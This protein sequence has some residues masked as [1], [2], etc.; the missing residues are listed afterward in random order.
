MSLALV[1]TPSA[2]IPLAMSVAALVTVIGYVAMFGTAPQ[3]DEGT[4]AHVWQL[5]MVGQV[6]VVAFFAIRWLPIE[7]GP[8]LRI[9]AVQISAALGAMFPVWWF[10]W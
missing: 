5:L 2:F 6:P 1:R 9:L 8:A 7:A 4:A 10:G 3:P